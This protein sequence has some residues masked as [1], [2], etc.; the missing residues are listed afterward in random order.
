MSA[1]GQQSPPRHFG[2]GWISGTLSVTL[3][4]VGLGTVFCFHFPSYLTLPE[5][6]ALYPLPLVRAVLH[7]VLVGGFLLGFT[8]VMLRHNKT[9][10]LVGVGS[11]LFSGLGLEI[12]GSTTDPTRIAAQVVTGV[13]FLG[14]GADPV[15]PFIGGKALDVEAVRQEF[16]AYVKDEM[17]ATR[18][19]L[20]KHITQELLGRLVDNVDGLM[21]LT[22]NLI[23]LRMRLKEAAGEHSIGP[24]LTTG[25][26]YDLATAEA[27]Q[28]WEAAVEAFNAKFE[29]AEEPE[30]DST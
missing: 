19:K 20:A 12:F 1:D 11:C 28:A 16:L 14:A 27:E 10:G 4:A 3:G 23:R 5:Y 7:L 2:T 22:N 25:E 17:I 29:W 21:V 30:G 13:G 18:G 26:P 9:L 15:W 24:S 6:R 8:S